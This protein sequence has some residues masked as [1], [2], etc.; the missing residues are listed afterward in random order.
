MSF[1]TRDR[2]QPWTSPQI[3]RR[4]ERS[5]HEWGMRIRIRDKRKSGTVANSKWNR[6]KNERGLKC[7]NIYMTAY[8]LYDKSVCRDMQCRVWMAVASGELSRR[9]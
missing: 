3:A 6:K 2:R 8:E 9:Y 5:G 1:A 7:R 4:V